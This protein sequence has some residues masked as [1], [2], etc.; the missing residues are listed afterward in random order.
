LKPVK[1][2][3]IGKE[4]EFS[5]VLEEDFM[6]DDLLQEHKEA[7]LSTFYDAKI[8]KS[9]DFAYNKEYLD[10]EFTK[11]ISDMFIGVVRKNFHITEPTLP[12]RPFVYIQDREYGHIQMHN[13]VEPIPSTISATF[14]TDIPENGGDF[15][16]YMGSGFGE[17]HQF[18]PEINKLYMFPGWLFHSPTPQEDEKPRICVN[19]DY[20]ST[21]RP[22]VKERDWIIW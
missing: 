6:V 7:M 15:K 5:Y 12:I 18:K 4:Y 3:H 2:K 13:H 21:M 10:K 14:Y 16:F 8:F 22:K 19:L 9:N 20:C 1:S 17:L 11:T